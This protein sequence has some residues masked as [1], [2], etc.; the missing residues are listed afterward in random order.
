[1]D[2]LKKGEES[3]MSPEFPEFFQQ[4][5]IFVLTGK[6]LLRCWGWEV[7]GNSEG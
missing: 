5:V 7:K 6:R 4:S 2:F 3:V 1:V